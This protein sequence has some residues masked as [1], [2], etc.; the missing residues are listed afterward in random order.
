MPT[1]PAQ[2]KPKPRKT[3]VLLT[4]TEWRAVKIAAATHD[5]SV[6]GYLS[7]TVLLRL[8]GEDAAALKAAKRPS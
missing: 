3:M 4:D 7:S 6:Q 1:P 2:Q 8:Q 5:T